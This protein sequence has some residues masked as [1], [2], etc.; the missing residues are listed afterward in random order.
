VS[1]TAKLLTVTWIGGLAAW[2]FAVVDPAADLSHV[3][4]LT[5]GFAVASCSI[6]LVL[7]SEVPRSRLSR[8]LLFESTY[9]TCVPLYFGGFIALL[10]PDMSPGLVVVSALIL[11]A[12]AIVVA[13]SFPPLLLRRV[14]RDGD[15]SHPPIPIT[16]A[17]PA[18]KQP[19]HP[20]QPPPV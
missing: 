10:L 6:P 2:T 1:R 12:G 3:L 9:R 7:L 14:A 18:E 15:N 11:A 20:M 16:P 4:A 17:T 5:A 13:T 8:P 19:K